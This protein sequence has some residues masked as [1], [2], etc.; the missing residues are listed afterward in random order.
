M[1]SMETQ[2]MKK[3]T[4][5]DVRKMARDVLTPA[6]VG[7]VLGMDPYTINVMVRECPERIPFPFFVSGRNVKI[8]KAGFIRWMDGNGPR[9]GQPA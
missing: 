3:Y 1:S 2:A 8:P 4:L 9:I 6:I 5:D 7:S